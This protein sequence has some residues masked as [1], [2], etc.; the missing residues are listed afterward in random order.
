MPSCPRLRQ[1][2]GRD[3]GASSRGLRGEVRGRK[4]T[5][6]DKRPT[7]APWLNKEVGGS[8][9]CFAKWRRTGNS[10]GVVTHAELQSRVDCLPRVWVCVRCASVGPRTCSRGVCHCAAC[11]RA[12]RLC[13]RGHGVLAPHRP[14]PAGGARVAVPPAA[15]WEAGPAGSAPPRRPPRLARQSPA[16]SSELFLLLGT[17]ESWGRGEGAGSRARA[18]PPSPSLSLRASRSRPSL[19]CGREPGLSSRIPHSPCRPAER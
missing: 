1:T 18:H 17:G 4:E 12:P 5:S 10:L 8:S 11:A 19:P 3:C 2:R 14:L 7:H 9:L 16:R 15:P 6:R 13:T